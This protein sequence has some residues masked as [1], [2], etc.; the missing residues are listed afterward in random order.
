MK[1]ES[2]LISDILIAQESSDIFL[3]VQNADGT[4]E[5]APLKSSGFNIDIGNEG[6]NKLRFILDRW[7]EKK[8]AIAEF[9]L[10][11]KREIDSFFYDLLALAR[12]A[13][14]LQVG[15]DHLLGRWNPPDLLHDRVVV[16]LL[17]EL[18]SIG[19]Q[20]ETSV[21]NT[22]GNKNHDF[23]ASIFRCE[24][25]SLRI[26]V[27]APFTLGGVWLE[28]ASRDRIAGKMRQEFFNASKQVGRDGIIFMTPL[29]ANLNAL[30]RGYFKDRILN[31]LPPPQAGSV[32][33]VLST[34]S[35]FRDC[36][37]IFPMIH[38]L[39]L[40]EK[41]ISDTHAFGPTAFSKFSRWPSRRTT[42][43]IAGSTVDFSLRG[44]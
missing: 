17:Q 27:D 34:Q 38:F 30:F 25:K 44:N 32:I 21:R 23:N 39:A 29:S 13:S 40:V 26:Q 10:T 2:E 31:H 43:P 5:S 19:Y 22:L 9:Y 37:L 6:I 18:S 28:R 8:K 4:K 15:H 11:E 41:A 33:L 24:V 35:P 16:Q 20:V 14:Q 36:Y 1:L 3:T 7:G 42:A 12:F